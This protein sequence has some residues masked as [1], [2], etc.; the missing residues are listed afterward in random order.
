MYVLIFI[1]TLFGIRE[2]PIK[3]FACVCVIAHGVTTLTVTTREPY[4]A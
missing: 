4:V 1:E 3:V 2:S